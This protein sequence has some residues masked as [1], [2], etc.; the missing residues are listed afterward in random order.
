MWARLLAKALTGIT[1]HSDNPDTALRAV[2]ARPAC[3]VVRPLADDWQ[4]RDV[5]DAHCHEGLIPRWHADT[6]I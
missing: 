5:I 4:A 6:E 3:L 1:P 2:R